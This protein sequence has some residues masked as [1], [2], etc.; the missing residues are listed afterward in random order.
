MINP[1]GTWNSTSS[2][3]MWSNRLNSEETGF[4]EM[5]FSITDLGLTGQ[6]PPLDDL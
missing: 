2:D 4:H 3:R 5:D 1:Q 6:L